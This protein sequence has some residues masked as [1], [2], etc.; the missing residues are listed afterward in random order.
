MWFLNDFE[1]FS[2]PAEVHFTYLGWVASNADTESETPEMF[3]VSH[4]IQGPFHVSR[5]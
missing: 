2:Y 1:F 4:G 5:R 3:T